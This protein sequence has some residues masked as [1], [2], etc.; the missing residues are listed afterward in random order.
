VKSMRQ[1]IPAVIDLT[2]HGH[3]Q[4]TVYEL[5]NGIDSPFLLLLEPA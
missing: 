2:S 1:Y 4:F 5:H 3:L